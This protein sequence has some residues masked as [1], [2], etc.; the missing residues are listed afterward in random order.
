MGTRGRGAD[1]AVCE[2]ERP[3]REV[4]H[5]ALGVLDAEHPLARRRG[6]HVDHGAARM[7]GRDRVTWLVHGL[8]HAS[9]RTAVPS[10][11]P[12]PS[13]GDAHA[14]HLRA[15]IRG[16]RVCSRR[17]FRSTMCRRRSRASSPLPPER[18]GQRPTRRW[19]PA[20]SPL[21]LREPTERRPWIRTTSTRSLT[22]PSRGSPASLNWKR[23]RRS[24]RGQRKKSRIVPVPL[25]PPPI[26]AVRLSADLPPRDRRGDGCSCLVWRHRFRVPDQETGAIAPQPRH[27]PDSAS[28]GG[29][30]MANRSN[31]MRSSSLQVAPRAAAVRCQ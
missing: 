20:E 3:A 9:E 26:T 7:R 2:P 18:R 10:G 23:T 17:P 24:P 11:A 6:S 28:S 27:T 4:A 1:S 22:F 31:M 12:P 30:T 5:G 19:A 16:A 15:G 14:L 13:G 29:Q 21:T 25:P 8:G